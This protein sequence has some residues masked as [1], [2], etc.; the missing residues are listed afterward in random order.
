MIIFYSILCVLGVL[1]PF[2]QFVP[3]LVDK[4]LDVSLFLQQASS[5]PIGSFAWLDVLVSALVLIAFIR[6]ESRRQ[7][8]PNSW[9]PIAGTCAVGVSFGFPLFLLQRELQRSKEHKN[10]KKGPVHQSDSLSLSAN[11]GKLLKAHNLKVATAESCTGG[12]VASHI[13]DTHGS[14]EY[15]E[16]GLI[17]YSNSAKIH[18]LDVKLDTLDT[19]GAVS[20]QTVKE[21]VS[22]ILKKTEADYGIAVSGY[23]EPDNKDTEIPAGLV[24]VG[25]G[26]RNNTTVK[27]FHFESDRS[28]NKEM[29]AIAALD[30]LN[31][32][33]SEDYAHKQA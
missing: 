28:R 8:I 11:I 33:L 9:L 26:S 16:Q 19:Y 17:T 5:N 14:S 29:A 25:V 10:K 30:L 24:Y 31:T 7:D 2:S 3:W 13:T 20:E 27:S 22:G 18:L 6:I 32:R 1:L 12:L 23:I 15:F 21:M 4:G